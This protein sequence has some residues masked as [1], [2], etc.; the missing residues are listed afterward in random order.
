MK[1]ILLLIF[2]IAGSTAIAQP[3]K[4]VCVGN[5]ITYGSGIANREKNSYPAQLAYAL[6]NEYA[7][8]N[9]GVSG[10]TLM[11]SGNAPYTETEEYKKSLALNPDIVLLKLG[12]NDAKTINREKLK[13]NYKRDYQT[14]ID[15]YLALENR[16]RIILLTPVNCYATQGQFVD[17]GQIYRSQIIPAIE[18]LAYEN[19]LEIIDLYHLFAD[20]WVE[21]LMPDKIHPSSIGATTMAQR[22]ASQ[23]RREGTAFKIEVPASGEF[24]FHGYRAYQMGANKIVEPTHAAQD[25]PWVLR[26]RFWGHEPQTDIALLEKGFHIAYCDVAD[27]YGSPEAVKRYD[28]FYQQMALAGLNRKVVLEAMSRGGLIA[29][30]WAARNADKVAAIY[31]DAPVLDIKSWPMGSGGNEEDTQNMLKAYNFRNVEAARR[32]KKNPIDQMKELAAIPIILVVGDADEVVPIASNS[33]IF[34]QGIPGIKVIHK[35]G[36]GHHPHSLFNPAPIV[37]FILSKTN[38]WQNPAIQ[39]VAGSEYRSGAG[40][41]EGNEWHSISAEI[42]SVVGSRKLDI[43]LIGNS[44]TQAFGGNRKLVTYAPGKEYMDAIS[45]SW[46]AA[47]I[48]G[49]RTQNVLWRLQN[50]DYNRSTPKKVIITIGV[51]NI[52]GGDSAEDTAAGIKAVLAEASKQFPHAKI[53]TFGLL[54]V[55]L[56]PTDA[57]RKKHDTIHQILAQAT[58][59]ENVTYLNLV[60]QLTQADGKLR[61]DLYSGDYLHLSAGGYKVWSKIVSEL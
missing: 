53:Y 2:L 18:E 4:V 6:G 55:G 48:S 8:T 30:N 7:V 14:L 21:H 33:T 24:N 17:A 34:E 32:W 39:A 31:A 37:E 19:S 49:D 43:L 52:Y 16:P 22:I 46:E 9:C 60:S 57:I 42:D 50:C 40:W 5:S 1:K 47:G 23:I 25:N 36:I 61:T 51:N 20:R 3:I 54:P 29:F 44:I 35:P 26:A 41:S 11:L 45:D 59:P 10:R 12:T 28:E 13:D 27:L 38:Q 15:S 58:M 56:N